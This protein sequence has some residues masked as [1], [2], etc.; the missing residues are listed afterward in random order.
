MVFG[1]RTEGDTTRYFEVTPEG[2]VVWDV[3]LCPSGWGTY[4]AERILRDVPI[5]H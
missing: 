3:E 1:T 5:G 2:E 4:R